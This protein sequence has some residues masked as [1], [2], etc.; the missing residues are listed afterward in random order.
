MGEFILMISL[1]NMWLHDRE[2]KIF[3]SLLRVLKA[4]A[5]TQPVSGVSGVVNH[6]PIIIPER[7]HAL[8]PFCLTVNANG[9]RDAKV[10]LNSH[11]VIQ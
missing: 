4:Q 8:M 10:R 2:V 5:K 7:S 9:R 11:A 3:S 1:E 6:S